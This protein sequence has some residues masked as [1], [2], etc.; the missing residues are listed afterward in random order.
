[1]SIDRAGARVVRRQREL[2]VAVVAIQE[3][4]QVFDPAP[5][6]SAGSNASSTELPRRGRHELHQAERALR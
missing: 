1:M 2:L 3:L 4:T 5:T 6:F